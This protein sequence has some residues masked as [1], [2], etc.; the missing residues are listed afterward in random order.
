MFAETPTMKEIK[1][2]GENDGEIR[3]TIQHLVQM[4]DQLNAKELFFEN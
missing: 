3:E 4:F 1:Y 2:Y